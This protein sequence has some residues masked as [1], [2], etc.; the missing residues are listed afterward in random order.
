MTPVRILLNCPD[1]ETARALAA[2][3]L[4]AGLVACANIYPEIESHYVWQ[5]ARQVES[6]V[7][8]ALKSRADLLPEIERMVRELHPYDVPPLV[9]QH[10]DF[11]HRPFADWI[12]EMTGGAGA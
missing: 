5:G 12:A 1:R 3:L 2:S 11:A 7:P 4:D 9:A 10:L 6:E 8:L